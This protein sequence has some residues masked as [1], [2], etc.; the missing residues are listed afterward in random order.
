VKKGSLVID[1]Y[2]NCNDIGI[3]EKTAMNNKVVR[4]YWLQD[5][6]SMT[7]GKNKIILIAPNCLGKWT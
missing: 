4:A 2:E 6:R 3:Y 1:T 5:K 7:I